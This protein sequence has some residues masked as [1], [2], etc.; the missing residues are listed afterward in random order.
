MM[1]DEPEEMLQHWLVAED[2]RS[3][4]E[5]QELED[6]EKDVM[7]NISLSTIYFYYTNLTDIL[8]TSLL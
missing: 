5:I 8:L 3:I 1:A 6:V 7:T 4:T 2:V